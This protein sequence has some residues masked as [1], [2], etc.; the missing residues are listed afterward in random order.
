MHQSQATITLEKVEDITIGGM[1]CLELFLL[2]CNVF[3]RNCGQRLEH[4]VSVFLL[5][6]CSYL[7]KFPTSLVVFGIFLIDPTG[8]TQKT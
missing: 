7:L 2:F 6:W 3:I 4:T 1:L 5:D 8:L